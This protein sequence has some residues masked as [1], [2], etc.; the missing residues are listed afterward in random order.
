MA[1][2]PTSVLLLALGALTVNAGSPVQKVVE[3]LGECKQKV[4]KDLEAEKASMT[5][6]SAYCDDEAKEKSYAIETAANGIES[7]KATVEE[8]TATIA[9]SDDEVSTL[10]TTIAS[11]EKEL[12]DAQGVRKTEHDDFV[13][14]EKELVESI[15]QLGRAATVLKKG[16]S[17]AQTRGGTFQV[18]KQ[19][20]EAINA[21]KTIVES[22]WVGAGSRRTLQSF[23]QSKA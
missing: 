11:K 14:A 1:R 21:L 20:Q 22:Q 19:T 6:F 15:D 18:N 12:A 13:A 3:L 10:G 23:F 9:T 7:L 16:M 4:L 8:C 5:E 2:M 17:F